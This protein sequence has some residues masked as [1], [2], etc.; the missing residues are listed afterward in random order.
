VLGSIYRELLSAGGVEFS[1]RSVSEYVSLD[2]PCRFDDL[3]YAAQQHSEIA[4]GLYLSDREVL[5]NPSRST[6]WQLAEDDKLIVLAQ[7][8]YR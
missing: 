7:Q 6:Q 4:L 8:I 3:T 5:L 2:T 1:L